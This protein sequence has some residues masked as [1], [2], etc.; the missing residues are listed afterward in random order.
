MKNLKT[1]KS[2]FTGLVKKSSFHTEW[3]PLSKSSSWALKDGKIFHK[4][5]R[6]FKI[7][8]L[9]GRPFINQHEIGT[10]G[11]LIRETNKGKEILI[12]AKIEPG[13]V[14]AVQLAPT[15]QATKSNLLRVHGG[16]TPP[17]SKIFAGKELKIVSST[18]HSEQGSRFLGK[19]N[20]N[21]LG[22]FSKPLKLPN[23]HRFIPV[24]AF[25]DLLSEDYLVNTDARSVLVTSPW[26]KLVDRIPFS[27]FKTN[28]SEELFLSYKQPVKTFKLKQQ[29]EKTFKKVPLEELKDWRIDDFGIEPIQKKPFRV[30]YL[31]VTAKNREVPKWDQ[32]IIDSYGNGQVDLI[33]GRI[34]GILHFH[35]KSIAE[36]GLYNH[37]ELSPT[38]CVEPG[39]NTETKDLV[40]IY[41]GKV[42][43]KVLQ[44]DEGGRF[45][46]DTTRYRIIDIGKADLSLN[47]YW[48]NLS[49]IQSLLLK[50]GLF[51]NE[52]R[53]VLSLLLYWL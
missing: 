22:I 24:D 39:E 26:N 11:F 35:F 10:L 51:T 31:K 21:I 7:V 45:Y 13:N 14:N 9:A 38:V 3:I 52:S 47:G 23:T 8:G 30:R 44:S 32:P 4:S 34:N 15:C 20:K 29:K 37:I 28:F 53:S 19:R 36:P 33:C 17:F 27:R 16:K 46:Q 18:L 12:Q 49:Q 40:K 2:W 25:L 42:I 43:K 50:D 5:G 48:F 41:K 6:F 1:L